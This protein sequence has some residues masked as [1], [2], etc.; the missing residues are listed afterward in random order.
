MTARQ[1]GDEIR[2]AVLSFRDITPKAQDS[3]TRLVQPPQKP[4]L[5]M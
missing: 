1:D 5:P 2:A 3:A 4:L